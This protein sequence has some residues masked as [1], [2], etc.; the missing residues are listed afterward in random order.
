M[1]AIYLVSKMLQEG[2]KDNCQCSCSA[3][4]KVGNGTVLPNH[5]NICSSSETFIN[6]LIICLF[7]CV[8]EN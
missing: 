8:G 3:H 4:E 6:Y 7:T 2:K 1:R 5:I